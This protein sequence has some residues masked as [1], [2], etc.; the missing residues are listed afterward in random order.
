MAS[1]GLLHL[2]NL[3]ASSEEQKMVW[4]LCPMDRT[5]G[6]FITLAYAHLDETCYNFTEAW[7]LANSQVF[8]LALGKL[9]TG[10]LI[11]YSLG[12]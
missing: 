2:F 12:P 1:T 9:Q 10:R 4:S 7:V 8:G 3:S 6:I 5:H 11:L